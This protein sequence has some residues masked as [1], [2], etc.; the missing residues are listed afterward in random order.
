MSIL[1]FLKKT[2]ACLLLLAATTLPK[3]SNA[4]TLV[5][6]LTS[7]TSL[8]KSVSQSQSL[9]AA[10]D[11]LKKRFGVVF[12]FNSRLVEGKT[13]REPVTQTQRLEESL[14]QMLTPW[15][16]AFERLDAKT[17]VIRPLRRQARVT[18][19][20]TPPDTTRPFSLPDQLPPI[21]LPLNAGASQVQIS[22][23]VTDN[24]GGGVPGVNVL[25]KGTTIGTT[26]DPEGKYALTIP[27]ANANGTLV[28]SYIGYITEETAI[29]GRTVV[30]VSLVP[31]IKSLSEVVVIGYG[32]QQKKEVTGSVASIAAEKIENLPV[33]GVD[34]ALTGQLAGVQV[35]QTTGAPGGNINVRIRGSG[36]IGAGNEPLYVVD[37]FPGVTN[38]NAI[39]PNDI[40]SIE[41]LKDASAAAIYGSR[42]ANGVVII[43]TKRGKS[44][45][46]KFN[47]DAY[48]G[49]QQVINKV[50][51]M[52]A[53]EYAR[54]AI[55]ARN[56]GFADRGGNPDLTQ[57]KNSNRPLQH[58]IF[59]PVPGKRFF[60]QCQSGFRGGNGLARPNL[61]GGS[62]A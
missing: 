24:A 45:Q 18:G 6:G 47:V 26:T 12:I 56:N 46:T 35:Q 42:G 11:Q 61:P 4:Q 48:T 33:T 44:G 49:L 19:T 50:E 54:H 14:R 3:Q 27:D 41:V 29:N 21:P 13:T 40:E 38:L 2:A 7:L 34:Q 10:L 58:Q 60:Q 20:P 36:S 28:F 31:D 25:L 9:E 62:R 59:P 8:P 5:S 1:L 15:E 55:R 57:V 22:G 52:N 53:T 16:L 17:Y 23:R 51:L 32:T 43:T 30:D 39:N 37:G